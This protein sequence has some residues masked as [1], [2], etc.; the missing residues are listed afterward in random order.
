MLFL[1]GVV[2]YLSG[3]GPVQG[4]SGSSVQVSNTKQVET[5]EYEKAK[6][7]YASLQKKFQQMI[8]EQNT[9]LEEAQKLSRAMFYPSCL[10]VFHF[11]T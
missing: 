8:E 2:E 3:T 11:V 7:E 1:N 5:D 6:E 10:A 4:S 9:L